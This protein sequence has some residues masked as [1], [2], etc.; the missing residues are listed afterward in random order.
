MVKNRC[1]W[2][3]L[4]VSDFRFIDIFLIGESYAFGLL[5]TAFKPLICG[6]WAPQK[7][8]MSVSKTTNDNVKEG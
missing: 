1:F 8:Q 6:K 7:P 5:K 2:K 3:S 4:I